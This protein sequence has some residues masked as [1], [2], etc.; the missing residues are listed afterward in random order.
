MEKRLRKPIN[1]ETSPDWEEKKKKME[2]V[3]ALSTT[4]WPDTCVLDFNLYPS[5]RNFVGRE[6]EGKTSPDVGKLPLYKIK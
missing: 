3:Q 1:L 4:Q 6:G 2:R 5:Q